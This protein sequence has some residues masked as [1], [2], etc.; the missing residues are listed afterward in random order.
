[1]DLLGKKHVEG[2]Y[3]P[4]WTGHTAHSRREKGLG[5]L[6]QKWG[7]SLTCARDE[8]SPRSSRKAAG[9]QRDSMTA[10]QDISPPVSHPLLQPRGQASLGLHPHHP[11]Q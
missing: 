1:M 4:L 9:T 7:H 6:L 8:A 10:R 5:T 2:L 3:V 11:L